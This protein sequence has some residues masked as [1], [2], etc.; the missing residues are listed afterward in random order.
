MLH[1]ISHAD[2]HRA[3]NQFKSRG[4]WE[5]TQLERNVWISIFSHLIKHSCAL[6]FNKHCAGRGGRPQ[7]R[8]KGWVVLPAIFVEVKAGN[9]ERL[10]IRDT[11]FCFINDI[12]Y[13]LS[14]IYQLPSIRPT[15]FP[16]LLISLHFTLLEKN[17]EWRRGV[18]FTTCSNWMFI[19]L[20]QASAAQVQTS[21]W[22][23]IEHRWSCLWQ[24]VTEWGELRCKMV[25]VGRTVKSLSCA[26]NR[27]CTPTIN[28][29]PWQ[30]SVICQH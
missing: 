26:H 9:R 30:D 4:V 22:Y 6:W 28:K 3:W 25:E 2:S 11:F 21:Y 8:G 1:I 23:V 27:Y 12:K 15:C 14:Y 24:A 16:P 13:I 20:L 5:Q 7:G 19:I 29:P 10:E 18:F 17:Q